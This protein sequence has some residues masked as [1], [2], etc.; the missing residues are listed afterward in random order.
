MSAEIAQGHP[1]YISEC[2]LI[3]PQGKKRSMLVSCAALFS[4][5]TGESLALASSNYGFVMLD[6]QPKRLCCHT[7]V[8]FL[9]VYQLNQVRYRRNRP[10]QSRS[11]VYGNTL[12]NANQ[13]EFVIPSVLTISQHL[14]HLKEG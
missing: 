12:M 14:I 13:L 5:R 2:S 7:R 3:L 1:S 4:A 10:P 8:F 6:S 11:T 9:A